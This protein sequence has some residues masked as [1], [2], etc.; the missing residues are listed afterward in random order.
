[1]MLKRWTPFEELRRANLEMDRLRRGFWGNGY[2]QRTR[3]RGMGHPIG[4]R[5][6]GWGV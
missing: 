6:E 4:C 5:R 3:A 2:G 1:M